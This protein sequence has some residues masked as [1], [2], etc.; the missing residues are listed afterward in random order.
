MYSSVHAELPSFFLPPNIWWSSMVHPPH[1]SDCPEHGSRNAWECYFTH[2]L[3]LRRSFC[4]RCEK[5]SLTLQA[6]FFSFFLCNSAKVQNWN[7]IC[8]I[9]H[10][11]GERER[12]PLPRMPRLDMI[13]VFEVSTTRCRMTQGCCPFKAALLMSCKNQAESQTYLL[14]SSLFTFSVLLFQM[15]APLWYILYLVSDSCLLPL[16]SSNEM[17]GAKYFQ[18]QSIPSPSWKTL[19]S[20]S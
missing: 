13:L 8:S 2:P 18:G 3:H 12:D 5:N 9:K 11:W 16:S 20:L 1:E 4:Q 19:H 6:I 14:V 17:R 10:I 7:A 15:Q